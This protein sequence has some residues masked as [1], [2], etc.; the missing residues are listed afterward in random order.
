MTEEWVTI[1]NLSKA[2]DDS[3][4]NIKYTLRQNEDDIESVQPNPGYP[5]YI[6]ISTL[7][8]IQ[9]FSDNM[10]AIWKY[11]EELP[12]VSKRKSDSGGGGSSSGSGSGVEE[13]MAM[14]EDEESEESEEVTASVRIN[15]TISLDPDVLLFYSLYR[16]EG[17]NYTI[18]DFI[19]DCVRRYMESLGYEVI[20]STPEVD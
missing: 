16:H 12:E 6:K 4:D 1:R 18:S 2:V 20:I 15:K 11:A 3:E 19:N 7:E 9:P 14:D 17:G 13:I 5:K 8:D 10:D